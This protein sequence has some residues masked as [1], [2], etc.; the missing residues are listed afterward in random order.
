MEAFSMKK[1]AA[2]VLAGCLLLGLSSCAEKENQVF[3][4]K[5]SD[6]SQMGNLGAAD[7]FSGMVVSESVTFINCC[8]K[9]MK[10]KRENP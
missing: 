1:A 4:Q 3:V 5:V 8:W 2:L 10:N 7:R 9:A 6:L